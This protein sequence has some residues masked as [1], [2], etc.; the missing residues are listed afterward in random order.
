VA[1]SARIAKGT[2]VIGVRGVSSWSVLTVIPMYIEPPLV[3]IESG[4]PPG[5]SLPRNTENV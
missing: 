3:K 2:V 5:V 1:F 4:T